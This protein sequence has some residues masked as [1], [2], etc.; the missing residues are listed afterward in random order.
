[1]FTFVHPAT[2]NEKEKMQALNM[3][4]GMTFAIKSL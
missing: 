2:R 4:K 1:L 3:I